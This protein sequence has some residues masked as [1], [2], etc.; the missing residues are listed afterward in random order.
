M[1]LEG[2][3]IYL[4]S[5]TMDDSFKIIQWRNS[6]SVRRFFIIQQDF[7]MESQTRWMEQVIKTGKAVQFL[8]GLKELKGIEI[9]SVYLKDIDLQ[10]KKAEYGIFIGEEEYRGSGFGTEAAKLITEYGFRELGLHKVYLQVFAENERARIS[11]RNAGF[12]EEAVLHEEV[13]VRGQF[14]DIVRMVMFENDGKKA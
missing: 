12:N 11:Y 6:D 10:N 2:N 5:V 9:G 3:R 7:T 4:R 1:R 8:I 14:H 13:F